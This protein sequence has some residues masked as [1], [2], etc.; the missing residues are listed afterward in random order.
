LK[1]NEQKLL[2]AV[3]DGQLYL[4]A[5]Y[6][7]GLAT[8]K[9]QVDKEDGK[10]KSGKV[11]VRHIIEIISLFGVD[12]VMMLQFMPETVTDPAAV[13]IP[14]EKGKKYAFPLTKMDRENGKATAFLDA[15]REVI[16]L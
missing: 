9:R 11:T 5:E 2:S 4:V 3:L 16:P 8:V 15:N 7:G 10:A 12:S 14:W 1:P 6:R 13:K